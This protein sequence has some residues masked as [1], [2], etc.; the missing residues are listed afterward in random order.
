Y[1][2]VAEVG[3]YKG[4]IYAVPFEM[5]AFALFYNKDI[6]NE[7]GLDPESPPITIED[8][9][10]M[11][12]KLW[13]IDD[14]GFYERI[15]FMPSSVTMWAPAFG[16]KWADADGNPTATDENILRTFEWF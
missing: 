8:L 5:N 15:G 10:G 9:D 11:Q 12:D 1:P 6:F 7:V 3:T 4:E 14:R 16:G 13:E 2:I